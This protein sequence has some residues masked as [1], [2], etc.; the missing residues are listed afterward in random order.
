M[1]YVISLFEYLLGRLISHLIKLEEFVVLLIKNEL[2]LWLKKVFDDSIGTPCE[3]GDHHA[4]CLHHI[5]ESV[6]FVRADDCFKHVVHSECWELLGRD[7]GHVSALFH[8]HLVEPDCYV[9]EQ[10]LKLL[11]L[12]IH[13]FEDSVHDS[14]DNF[15]E[16]EHEIGSIKVELAKN[17]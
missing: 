10:E 9:S 5:D 14:A 11:T 2:S 13:D 15:I 6:D 4:N 12:N 17:K 16:T 1:S 3:G 7:Q 8:T